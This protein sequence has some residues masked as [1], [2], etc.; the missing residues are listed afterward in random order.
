[1]SDARVAL[2]TG[3]SRGIGRATVVALARAGHPVAFCFGSDEAGAQETVSLVE[4]DGGKAV[5]VRA[6]VSDTDAVARAF[7]EVESALGPVHVLVNNAGINR[8]GLLVRMS[9]EHWQ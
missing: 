2:V 8:D 4:A 3:G 6:D 9:D 1:M 7:D 5:S